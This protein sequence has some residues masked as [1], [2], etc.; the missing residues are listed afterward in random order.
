MTFLPRLCYLLLI[1]LFLLSVS[2]ARFLFSETLVKKVTKALKGTGWKFYFLWMRESDRPF[3]S[4]TEEYDIY[5]VKYSKLKLI[6]DKSSRGVRLAHLKQ[7]I[8]HCQTQLETTGK[9]TY[10][11]LKESTAGGKK[12][13]PN[14]PQ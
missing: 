11:V 12:D 13:L 1:S 3:F 7:A 9:C 10:N 14:D 6:V 2:A 8:D 4:N 5:L